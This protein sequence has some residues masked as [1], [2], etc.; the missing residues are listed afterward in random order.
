MEKF[1]IMIK[2]FNGFSLAEI[3]ITIAIFSIIV[4]S[5]S[6]FFTRGFLSIKKNKSMLP[7]INMLNEQ[8]E[9][10]RKMTYSEFKTNYYPTSGTI[11]ISRNQVNYKMKIDSVYMDNIADVTINIEWVGTKEEGKRNLTMET[12]IYSP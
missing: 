8:I 4:V 3:L 5:I 7:A 6:I 11:T 9:K 2:K 1:I 10:M 12:Y